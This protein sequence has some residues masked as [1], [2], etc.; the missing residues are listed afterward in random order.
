LSTFSIRRFSTPDTLQSID[1]EHL[2]TF[3]NPYRAFF[4]ARGVELPAS[5]DVNAF[6]YDSLVAVLLNPGPDTPAP[7]IDALYYVNEMAT[8]EG[9]DA[10][11]AAADAAGLTITQDP[12]QTPADVAVQVWNLDPELV[13]E[14][15]AEQFLS[16]QRTFEHFQSTRPVPPRSAAPSAQSLR[17]MEHDLDAW[18]DQHRRGRGARVFPVVR[19]G[20][21]WV[22]VRPGAPYRREGSLRDGEPSIVH[23]RPLK[24]DIVGYDPQVDELRINTTTKGEKTLYRETFG[25]HLFNDRDR[26]PETSTKYALAP[27]RSHGREALVCVDISGMEWVK[28]KEVHFLWGGA[29]GEIEIRKAADVFAAYEARGSKMP[30]RPRILRASFEV[31]FDG[32]RRPRTVTIKAPNVAKYTRDSDSLVVERWLEARGF[33]VGRES[34]SDA[35]GAVLASA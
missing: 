34:A 27:L 8:A 12:E 13:Q 24:F 3:L 22:L 16:S 19:Q 10:L 26:F 15:H 17:A 30:E 1:P 25:E 5:A 21:P 33:I 23:Y 29:H 31:K 11:L 32:A 4:A 28:L 18:F 35:T 2:L 6:D 7:L 20:G 14:K 9:M